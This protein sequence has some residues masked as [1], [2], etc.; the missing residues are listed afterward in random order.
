MATGPTDLNYIVDKL[1]DWYAE[2]T[3][4]DLKKREE[5]KKDEFIALESKLREKVQKTRK[6]QEQR[7]DEAGK[8]KHSYA[9]VMRKTQALKELF[10]EIGEGIDSMT[11]VI[12]RSKKKNDEKTIAE[13]LRIQSNYRSLLE[14]LKDREKDAHED[15]MAQKAKKKPKL[16]ESL[17]LS[18]GDDELESSLVDKNLDDDESAALKKFRENDKKIDNE[19]QKIIYGMDRIEQALINQDQL[20][21][22]NKKVQVEVEGRATDLNTKFETTNTRL[23]K[24]LLQLRAPHKVCMDVAMILIFLVLL[25]ILYKVISK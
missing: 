19:L 7:N 15:Q 14:N 20:I 21:D 24:V 3:G 10:K 11:K 9:I 8:D 4:E 22:Q 25:G 17:D 23:K 6:I 2:V 12:E 16:N 18:I 5:L 1:E 13:R